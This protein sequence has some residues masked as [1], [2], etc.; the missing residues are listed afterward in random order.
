MEHTR[1]SLDLPLDIEPKEAKEISIAEPAKLSLADGLVA[2]QFTDF[3]RMADEHRKPRES[4]WDVSWDLYNGRYDWTG[5]EDWQAKVNIPKVRGVVDKATGN[6]RRALIRMKRF[7][8]IESETRLGIEQGYFTMNLLDYWLDQIDFVE[9]FTIGL[10]A[11]LITSTL[12]YKVWWDWFTSAEPRWETRTRTQPIHEF[13]IKVGE[14]QVPERFV[15]REP[16]TEGRLGIKAIDPYNF[17]IGEGNKYRIEKVTVD[18]SHLEALAKKGVY[19]QEAVDMLYQRGQNRLATAKEQARKQERT[20]PTEASRFNRPVD[21]YHYWGDLYGDDGRVI[22]RNV[23]YTMGDR[24]VVLRKPQQN[25]LFHGRDPYVVGTPYIVPFS[26]YHR[27]IVE[28]VNGIAQMITNL[29]CLI[30]DGA[31]FDAMQAFEADYELIEDAGTKSLKKGI[32]PGIVVPTKAYENTTNRSVVRPIQ[33]G[34]IPQLAIQIMAMLDRE[35]QL[36]TSV[37]N[38]T[39]G[40]DIGAKTLGEFQSLVGGASEGLDEAAR[41]V[42]DTT[43]NELLEK[44]IATVYQYNENYTLPRLTE[45]FPQTALI[46]SDMTPEERYATMLTDF[47]FKARGVSIMMDKAQDLKQIDTFTKLVSAIPGVM[48]RINVDQLLENIVVGIGWN[49]SRILLNPSSSPVMPVAMQAGQ[50]VNPEQAQA[51][52]QVAQS[53]ATQT[54]AQIRAGQQGAVMGGSRNNPQAVTPQRMAATGGFPAA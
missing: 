2:E 16:I 8:H 41:T 50:P 15:T 10:K 52:Q 53:A 18:H 31:Q 30:I 44:S 40:Q 6:F 46:L 21:I 37:S 25:P 27:G 19:S 47:S 28:D 22:A 43:L 42:E 5:K 32:Y 20:L 3:F 4:V 51:A 14:V 29:A 23:L 48:A 12:I 1:D 34:K 54:P 33:T 24:D 36:S 26:T 13:G 7:Y 17:W 11:G 39:R 38:A 45:N 9:E 49:P 35:Q